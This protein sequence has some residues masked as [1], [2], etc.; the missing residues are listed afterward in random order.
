MTDKQPYDVLREFPGF[1]LR[2]YPDYVLV[3]LEVEGDFQGAG[4]RGFGPLF[5]YISGGNQTA[6][7]IAMTAPVIQEATSPVTH[8]VSFVLPHGMDPADVP[9]PSDAGVHTTRV[10]AHRAAARRFS[11][12]WSEARFAA[13]GEELLGSVRRAGL[14]A[15]GR[16]YFA[17]F[18]PPWKPGFLK[19][20]EAL[21][22]VAGSGI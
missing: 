19:H 12:G 3:Q 20:N 8:T 4:N 14:T 15:E 11:G 9:V 22:A 18:D 1:E 13:N 5:R 10:P 17:R 16:P 7:R 6:T 2:H 21:V